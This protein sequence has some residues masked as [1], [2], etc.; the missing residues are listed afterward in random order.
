MS[1]GAHAAAVAGSLVETETGEPGLAAGCGA[2][3]APEVLPEPPILHLILAL[4]AELGAPSQAVEYTL[5][6]SVDQYA[7]RLPSSRER[8]Q[9]LL[10]P[11]R[12]LERALVDQAAR[13]RVRNLLRQWGEL[14]KARRLENEA[15]SPGTYYHTAMNVRSLPGP[16][17]ARCG[18]PLLAEDPVVIH[19]T[20][21]SHL[22]CPPAW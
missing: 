11:R 20:L 19:G 22:A 2:A 9:T 1:Q 18:G 3:A 8:S 21:R 4:L 6:P 12:A 17:C 13:I 14:P 15:A 7:I 16:R 5:L 10:L